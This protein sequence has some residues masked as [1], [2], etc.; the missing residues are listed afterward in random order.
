MNIKIDSAVQE[1]RY[2]YIRFDVDGY[3]ALLRVG[4]AKLD[5]DSKLWYAEASS[6][7]RDYL[8]YQ[9]FYSRDEAAAHAVRLYEKVIIDGDSSF[10]R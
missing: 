3:S 2:V 7:R 4:P 8:V 6:V 10:G 1:E 9:E 5:P